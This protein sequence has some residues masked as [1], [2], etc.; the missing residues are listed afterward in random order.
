MAAEVWA[1]RHDI[2]RLE[3]TVMTHN[4]PAV[5]LYRSHG[6]LIEGTRTDSLRVG[7]VFVD[8]YAMSKML[9]DPQT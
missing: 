1:R 9:S 5:H 3:L 8:E 4:E 7:G 2:H 6:F